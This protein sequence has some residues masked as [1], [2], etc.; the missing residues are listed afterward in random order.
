MEW[1]RECYYECGVE[2]CII[3]VALGRTLATVGQQKA[4]PK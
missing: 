1:W 2:D 3:E 4:V